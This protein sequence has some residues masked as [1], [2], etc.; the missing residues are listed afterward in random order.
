[1]EDIIVNLWDFIRV[2]IIVVSD[3]GNW[4]EFSFLDFLIFGI[5]YVLLC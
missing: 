5:E 4:S 1:M 3:F 2:G